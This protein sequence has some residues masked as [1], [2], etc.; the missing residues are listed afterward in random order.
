[1]SS[2]INDWFYAYYAH[3]TGIDKGTVIRFESQVPTAWEDQNLPVIFLTE[4]QWDPMNVE[5]GGMTRDKEELRT[6]ISLTTG[7]KQREIPEM[8]KG[9]GI[10]DE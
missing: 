3:S 6:I 5:L 10:R 2:G 1:M 9:Q 8:R 7:M 4:E